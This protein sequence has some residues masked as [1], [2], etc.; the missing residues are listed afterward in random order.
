MDTPTHIDGSLESF[1]LK[2][3]SLLLGML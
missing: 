1:D 2:S 3:R